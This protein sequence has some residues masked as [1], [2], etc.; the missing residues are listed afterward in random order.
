MALMAVKKSE[1]ARGSVDPTAPNIIEKVR[2]VSQKQSSSILSSLIPDNLELTI[3]IPDE[4]KERLMA[5]LDRMT[6]TFD[7]RWKITQWLIIIGMVLNA[8]SYLIAR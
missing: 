1:G 6:D 2:K 7:H 3:T 5:R 4:D 8:T